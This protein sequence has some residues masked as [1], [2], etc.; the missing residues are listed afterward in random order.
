M[1]IPTHT[2]N[3]ALTQQDLTSAKNKS[4]AHFKSVAEEKQ[5]LYSSVHGSLASP[6]LS[7]K[8]TEKLQRKATRMAERQATLIEREQEKEAMKKAWYLVNNYQSKYSSPD[9]F[10]KYRAK[11]AREYERQFIKKHLVL[12]KKVQG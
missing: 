8:Q 2:S 9:Q 10:K 12:P 1:N 11:K 3:I 6:T 5:D 4:S 7:K